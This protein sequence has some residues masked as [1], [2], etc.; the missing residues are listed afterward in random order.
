MEEW[1]AWKDHGLGG[2]RRQ[3][4]TGIVSGARMT[5]TRSSL[6]TCTDGSV[7]FLLGLNKMDPR[8]CKYGQT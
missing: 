1:R 4:L 3:L 5:N 7:G 6:P 8:S 2:I